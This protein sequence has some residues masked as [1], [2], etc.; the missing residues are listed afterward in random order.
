MAVC[1][2]GWLILNP[3]GRFG[4]CT[5]GLVTYGCIPRPASDIQVRGDGATRTVEKTHDLKLADVQWLLDPLPGVLIISVGWDG[6]V[7]PEKAIAGIAQCEV[8]ILKTG[9]AL[10]LYNALKRQGQKI[11]IHVHSTC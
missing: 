3:P 9:E 5:F 2:A 4:I 8:R 10:K 6:A 1:L 11:A 7:T